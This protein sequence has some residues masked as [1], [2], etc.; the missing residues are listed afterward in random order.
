M[1]MY[2]R[3]SGS[4]IFPETKAGPLIKD[5][6]IQIVKTLVNN[7]KKDIVVKHELQVFWQFTLFLLYL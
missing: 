3:N 2:C 1:V 4:N 7:W 6:A 5:H